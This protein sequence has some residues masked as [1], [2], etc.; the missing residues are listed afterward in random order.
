ME[1]QASLGPPS[2]TLKGPQAAQTKPGGFGG[3]GGC[4][5]NKLPAVKTNLRRGVCGEVPVVWLA[6]GEGWR[7]A[8]EA[9]APG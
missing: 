2:Q 7:G 5:R 6:G 1:P 3:R 9:G 8:P 4:S